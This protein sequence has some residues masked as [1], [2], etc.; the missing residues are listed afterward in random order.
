ML[1]GLSG[2]AS[3]VAGSSQTLTVDSTPT[4]ATCRAERDGAA[5]QTGTTPM[6]FSVPKT[7]KDILISCKNSNNE[8]GSTVNKSGIEGWFLGNLIIG[9]LVGMGIDWASGAYNKYDTPTM[10][11]LRSP[12]PAPKTVS[13]PIS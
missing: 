1:A 7:K 11:T 13:K 6:S 2:C 3:I 8:V 5:L 10:V 4:G 12:E 9:G